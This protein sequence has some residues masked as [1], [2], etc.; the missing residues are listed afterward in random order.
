MKDENLAKRIVTLSK[1][2]QHLKAKQLAYGKQ[3]QVFPQQ[4]VHEFTVTAVPSSSAYLNTY[5]AVYEFSDDS[6][7]ILYGVKSATIYRNGTALGWSGTISNYGT[8]YEKT[9]DGLGVI[10]EMGYYVGTSEKMG[11]E[12]VLTFGVPSTYTVGSVVRL[13]ID[14]YTTAQGFFT[15]TAESGW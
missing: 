1:E 7:F 10:M 2:V 4:I 8:S 15:K 6:P 9:T 14:M 11:N 12:I 3:Y 13:V 5:S